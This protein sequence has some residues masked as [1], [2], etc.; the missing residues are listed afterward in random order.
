MNQA[1]ALAKLRKVI[2]PKL[3]YRIDPKAPSAEQ[4]EEARTKLR[5]A[6]ERRDAVEAA[7]KA[8]REELLRD[9]TY[10]EL[11]K[12]YQSLDEECSLHSSRSY[13]KRIT[14]GVAGGM[15]FS[16]RAEGDNWDEVVA[17][18]TGAAT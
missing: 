14:V 18:A 5:D 8:R 15:F 11:R 17:K 13:K 3:G 16:V 2:G 6:R 12:Q 4:R 10:Q 1:Q 7:M 9:P